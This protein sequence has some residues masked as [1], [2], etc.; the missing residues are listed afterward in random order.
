MVDIID[1]DQEDDDG[2]KLVPLG[3][4]RSKSQ[5]IG[6]R[7]SLKI[8]PRAPLLQKG[9]SSRQAGRHAA[10]QGQHALHSDQESQG[11]WLEIHRKWKQWNRFHKQA[12]SAAEDRDL[13]SPFCSPLHSVLQFAKNSEIEDPTPLRSLLCE[14]QKRAAFRL[15]ALKYQG[16]LYDIVQGTPYQRFV[17]GSQSHSL[18]GSALDRVEA[19]GE[20]LVNK[21]NE[22]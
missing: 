2:E 16:K 6:L 1:L 3:V 17:W 7:Q 5:Q 11:D 21:I 13:T 22:R 15:F 18:T 12:G 19:C 14:Q 8:K 20:A 10:G 9:E 4:E